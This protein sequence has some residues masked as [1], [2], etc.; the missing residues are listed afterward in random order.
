MNTKATLK[1]NK[2]K[3]NAFAEYAGYKSAD[4]MRKVLRAGKEKQCI[5]D[6][7][8]VYLCKKKGINIEELIKD[9]L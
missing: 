6:C 3:I 2:I 4:G 8:I 9:L 1:K 7:L 5:K